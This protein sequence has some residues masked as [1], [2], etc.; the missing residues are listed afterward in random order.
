MHRREPKKGGGSVFD[1]MTDSSQ[2]TG[3]HKQRFDADG[4]GRGAAGRD[5]GAVGNDTTARWVELIVGAGVGTGSAPKD[6]SAMVRPQQSN[7][8]DFR[9]HLGT[10]R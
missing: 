3:M 7:V 8:V 2:Y 5:L 6:L 9:A 4:Q 10:T 1:R